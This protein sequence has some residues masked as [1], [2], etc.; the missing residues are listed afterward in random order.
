MRTQVTSLQ[1]P[2]TPTPRPASSG[3]LFD[4]VRGST[5]E[6]QPVSPKPQLLNRASASPSIK[7][8]IDPTPPT[9]EPSKAISILSSGPG[10]SKSGLNSYSIPGNVTP[11]RTVSN[12]SALQHPRQT[13]IEMQEARSRKSDSGPPS[14]APTP[15]PKERQKQVPPP[16]PTGSGLLSGTPFGGLTTATNGAATT[17]GSTGKNIWLTFELKGQNNVYINFSREV[18]QKYGFAALHP[19]LAA[20]NERRKALAAAGAELEKAAGIGSADDMSLDMSE[21]ESPVEP[22]LPQTDHSASAPKR[23]KRKAEDYDRN[24]DFIDDAEMAW[25]ESALMAKDGFFVYSGPLVTEGERP[26]IER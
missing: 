19:R 13:D 2:T 17:N 25:Q 9:S 12:S 10:I 22:D 15:P 21:P 5:V 16:L 6:Y 11:Q 3:Q 1:P 20:R 23:R 4:P 24:D 26:A 8:L 18:E 14:Q 7:S